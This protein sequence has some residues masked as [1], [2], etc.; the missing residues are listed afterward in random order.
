V[1]YSI[2]NIKAPIG[3]A[4]YELRKTLPRKIAQQMPSVEELE[5]QFEILKEMNPMDENS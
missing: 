4:D 2:R 5:E 1:Q 3:V